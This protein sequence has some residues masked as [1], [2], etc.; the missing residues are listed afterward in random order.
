MISP[1]QAEAALREALPSYG[2]ENTAHLE[3]VKY[4]ENHVFRVD[5]DKETS[6][7][8]RLHRLGYR[9][10]EQL[11]TE[12]AYLMELVGHGLSVPRLIRTLD[13]QLNCTVVLSDGQAVVIDLQHWIHDASP[14]GDVAE[15]IAGAD[16]LS[17]QNFQELGRELAKLH[18]ASMAIGIPEGFDR[19]AWDHEGLAGDS[20]L[21]GDPANL[22]SLDDEQRAKISRA[23]LSLHGRLGKLRRDEDVFGVIH[24]DL[25]PENVLVSAAGPVLIDFDDFG[26]G[27]HLFDLATVLFF[28]SS[29]PR[30]AEYRRGLETGYLEERGEVPADFFAGWDDLLLCRGLTYLGWAAERHGDE[31]TDF[32]ERKVVPVV[33]N[34]VE[35]HLDASTPFAVGGG[36]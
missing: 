21:W 30:L 29:H 8:A 18:R 34:L 4:R 36:Q 35:A 22:P 31:E 11:S 15:A 3:L 19:G 26:T 32:I 13:G 2:V 1:T 20:P 6:Y 16:A 24:A 5:V 10:P 12:A 25:T 33:M 28:Y 9:T 27:W 17:G 23:M 7:A 14:M